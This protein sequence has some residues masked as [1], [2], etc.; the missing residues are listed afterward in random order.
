[1]NFRRLMLAIFVALI[2]LI[3]VNTASAHSVNM[4]YLGIH[5]EKFYF[6]ING[7]NTY[8]PLMCDAF[9][10]QIHPG[11][12]WTANVSPLLGGI[13][14][15]MFGSSMTLDYK[16]AGLIYKSMLSGTL[17]I[18]QTQWAVWGLFSTNARDTRQFQYL[19][20]AAIDATYLGLAQNAPN[21]AY[22]GL[23]LYT[24]V[25]GKA[26]FGPQEFIGYHCSTVPEPGSLTLLGT[27][28]VMLAGGLRRK[29][30]K[31]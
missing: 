29:F 30:M 15:G 8:T 24:P 27:G 5:D 28:L 4:K 12:T 1:M 22:A 25:G 11:E 19:G 6:S 16:A 7:S 2:S 13:A 23:F 31:A 21:S 3:F 10:N 26:G 20:G 17:N 18:T 14:K 9:D